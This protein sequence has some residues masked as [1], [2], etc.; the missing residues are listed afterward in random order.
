M[1]TDRVR[2]LLRERQEQ[3]LGLCRALIRIPSEDPPGDNRPIAGFIR[4]YL[5]ARGVPVATHEVE[6]TCPNLVAPVR[7]GRGG[8]NI[9]FNG[10]METLPVGDLGQWKHDPFGAEI[11]A[12]RLYGRGTW[13]MKGGIAAEIAAALALRDCES[14]LAG[15]IT[16]A[17]VSDEVNGGGRGTGYVLEQVEEARGDAALVGEGAHAILFGHKGPVFVEFTATGH[18]MQSAY[19]F[20]GQSAN[21]RMIEL[22]RDVRQL[23]G[24]SGDVPE[25]LRRYIEANRRYMDA[26]FGAGATDAL[27]Q[28]TVNVG[29]IT[30]GRKVNMIADRCEA[31]VD[32]RVPP[33]LTVEQLTAQID[34]IVQRHP[35]TAYRVRWAN[36]PAHSSPEHPWLQALQRVSGEVLD[37]PLRFRMSH[38][39]TDARFFHLRG[40]PAAAVGRAGG[41][42]GAPDEYIE[43]DGLFRSAELMALA[44]RDFLRAPSDAPQ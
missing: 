42:A 23:G 37:E 8:R 24:Q 34:A 14:D 41:I 21:H 19:I 12:D 26:E 3:T 28:L 43:V 7:L 9:V 15:T 36:A 11:V 4:D 35:G 32:F 30:G 29:T 39:F 1:S 38:G 18:A 44:A 33:G 16:L 27:L 25:V 6:A 40:I 5:G 17:F 2:E 31:Q 22:L 10:H 20:A 13:C